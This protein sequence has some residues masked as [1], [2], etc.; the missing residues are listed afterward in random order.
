[1]KRERRS[2]FGVSGGVEDVVVVI[3]REVGVERD[4]EDPLLDAS[5]EPML[6]ICR[7]GVGVSLGVRRRTVP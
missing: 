2:R 4:V 6:A 3:G 1:M 5:V 7:K